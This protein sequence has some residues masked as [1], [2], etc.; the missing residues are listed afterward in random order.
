MPVKNV[1]AQAGAWETS[2]SIALKVGEDFDLSTVDRNSHP[3]WAADK[4]AGEAFMA[5][6]GNLLSELQE[7]FFANAKFGDERKL[8]LIVQGLDTAG[9]GGIAR[10]VLGMVDPQGVALS[11]FGVPTEEELSHHYL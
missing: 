1:K 6:R 10:H 7:R 11:S 4:A 5:E 9:K 3:G 8:L 2:P